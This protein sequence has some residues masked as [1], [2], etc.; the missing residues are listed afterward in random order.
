MKKTKEDLR[1]EWEVTD[2][3]EPA[4]IVGIEITRN[5][6]SI[7]I[8]QEMYIEEILKGEGMDHANPVSMPMDPNVKIE[9]NPDGNEGDRSNSYARLIGE[10]QYLANATWPDI[11][12]AV[13]RLAS[14][15]A[16]PSLQYTGA[17]K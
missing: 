6:D 10:L 15:T 3:G 12:Y 14:Y 4:K 7:T 16:N 1:S 13:N 8:S 2:L 11:T 5:A 17:V 9:L